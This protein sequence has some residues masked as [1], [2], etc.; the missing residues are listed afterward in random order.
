MD[1]WYASLKN[2]KLIAS[3]GWFF[4][5]WLKSNRLVNPDR[6]GNS[7]GGNPTGGAGGASEG[8]WAC[9]GISSQ[10]GDAEYWATNDLK[11]TEEKREELE[12]KGWG[13][14]RGLK[15]CC[16]VE[17]QIRH[18]IQRGHGVVRHVRGWPRRRDALQRQPGLQQRRGRRHRQQRERR[19]VLHQRYRCIRS[20]AHQPR[21]RG[22]HSPDPGHQRW[23]LGT[24]QGSIRFRWRDSN[25][26]TGE[27]VALQLRQRRQQP[28][29]DPA[30]AAVHRLPGEW[31]GDAAVGLERK[32]GRN[33]CG[34]VQRNN[35]HIWNVSSDL[36]EVK[37]G[38][39]E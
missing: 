4:L 27:T 28:R 11:M 33:F 21:R 17:R 26:S 13:I 37:R 32:L 38:S 9:S 23:L 29:P 31:D 6:Q 36:H 35:E 30:R 24:E 18:A 25:L 22:A 34:D 15:Q 39:E 8:L 3:F 16:G 7:G 5:T 14:H 2:L 1:S 19:L 10:N 12:K 20:L